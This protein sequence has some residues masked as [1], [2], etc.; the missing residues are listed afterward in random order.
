LPR[1]LPSNPN[2]LAARVGIVLLSVVGAAG[3]FFLASGPIDRARV[4]VAGYPPLEGLSLAEGTLTHIGRCQPGGRGY[5]AYLPVTLAAASGARYESLDCGLEG[6]LRTPAE[7]H[8]LSVW[9]DRRRFSDGHVREVDM[10][11]QVLQSYVDYIARDRPF[12]PF[13]LVG[14]AMI[15]GTLLV[16]LYG[17]FAAS[18]Q[19]A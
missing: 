1:P 3:I 4:L 13:V 17:F 8:H 7:A 10:D 2:S 5:S 19:D 16:F 9:R 15:L 12:A 6:A 14:E 11:G 18:R